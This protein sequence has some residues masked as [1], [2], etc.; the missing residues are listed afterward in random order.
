MLPAISYSSSSSTSDATTA[1]SRVGAADRYGPNGTPLDPTCRHVAHDP[2]VDPQH[3]RHLVERARVGGEVEEVVAPLALVVDL[4][5]ELAS[6]PDVVQVPGAA[7]RSTSSRARATTSP[8]R[9]SSSSGSSSSKISYSFTFPESPSFGLSRPRR[10]NAPPGTGGAPGE[11]GSGG[12]RTSSLAAGGAPTGRI[13]HPGGRG[14]IAPCA[15]SSRS[16]SSRSASGRSSAGGSDA[17]QRRS[18]RARRRR[19]PTLR[20][21]LRQKLAES[22]DES[23]ERV[24]DV[25]DATVEDRRA[26]VH[27]HARAALD[28]M[29]STDEG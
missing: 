6:P 24:R 16:R 14:T 7:A 18:P 5:G 10:S 9:S 28:D 8:W 29:S 21:E 19:R 20:D 1:S 27:E 4:V 12:M 13:D 11:A 23:P 2:V 25:P 26:E 15:S 22:R 3:P 17:R